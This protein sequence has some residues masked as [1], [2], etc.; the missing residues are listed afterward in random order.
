MSG[1]MSV[2]GR[3]GEGPMRAGAAVADITAGLYGAL[4]ILTALLEREAS[5]E[6]QWVQSCLLQSNIAL[7]DFIAAGYLRTG[8]VPKQVGNDHPFFMPTSAYR[9]KDGFLNISAPGRLWKR[10]CEALGQAE[11]AD[12]REYATGSDRSKNREAL[13]NELNA[14]FV[15]RTTSEWVEHLNAA[16]VPA[17]PIYSLDQTFEDP[18]VK[19]LEAAATVNHPQ[20]G[21]MRIVNQAAKLTRTPATMARATPERGEHT[22]EVLAQF[23]FTAK[24]IEALRSDGAI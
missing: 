23:G 24:Q 19:H 22:D 18:Q 11:L 6:G 1:F 16:G 4:G 20:I 21:P 17:G 8:Q 2:T 14:I 15:T 13:K 9:T 12:R 7:L 10:L 5:G 3:A